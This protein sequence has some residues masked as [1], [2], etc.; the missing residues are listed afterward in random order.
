MMANSIHACDGL[1]EGAFQAARKT[2]M[3]AWT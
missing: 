1:V 2:R 3:T